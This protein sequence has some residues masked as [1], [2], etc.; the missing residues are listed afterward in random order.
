MKLHWLSVPFED[1]AGVY[2][3][4][5]V[6]EG[7]VVA[8][9][10]DGV[11]HRFEAVEVVDDEAAKEGRAVLERGFVDDD[12]CAFGLD[13]LQIRMVVEYAVIRGFERG[14]PFGVCL[15]GCRHGFSVFGFLIG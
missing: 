11:A 4:G 14:V 6:I 5:D 2:A 1:I 3:G 13:A 15:F 12:C 9:G 10:D 8:V 7:G